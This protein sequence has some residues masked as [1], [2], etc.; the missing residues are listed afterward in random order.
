[1]CEINL[2]SL[3]V[4]FAQRNR[5]SVTYERFCVAS[6]KKYGGERACS[7]MLLSLTNAHNFRVRVLCVCAA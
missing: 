7:N 6:V 1:M 4:L 3:L 2:F 5:S